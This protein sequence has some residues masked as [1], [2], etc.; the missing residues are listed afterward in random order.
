MA[1]YFNLE[2]CLLS[3]F[4]VNN[5]VIKVRLFMSL[6]LKSMNVWLF[7]QSIIFDR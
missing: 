7:C 3:F 1:Q 6:F 4:V 2:W 5:F